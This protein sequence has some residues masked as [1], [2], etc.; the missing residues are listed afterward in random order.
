MK[1]SFVEIIVLCIFLCCLGCFSDNRKDTKV[2]SADK[3]QANG[4]FDCETPDVPYVVSFDSLEQI[5]T[6]K[7]MLK[8]D[9]KMVVDYLNSNNYSMNGITSKR[10]IGELFHEIGDLCMLHLDATSGYELANVSYY[11]SYH[12]IMS[13]YKNGSDMVRLI[14]Y[15]GNSDEKNGWNRTGVHETDI[16]SNI[17]IGNKEIGLH[18]VKDENSPFTF[19]SNIETTNSQISILF[20]EDNEET[21]R[22]KIGEYIVSSTLLELLEK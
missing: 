3:M 11:V 1:K 18:H 13:T 2:Q 22:N 6:L 5:K 4:D 19:A 21:I 7:N 20:S 15:I 16:V 17:S 12:Y 9:D 8:E 14:C 10:D